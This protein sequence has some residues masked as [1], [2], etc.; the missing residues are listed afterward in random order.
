[1]KPYIMAIDQGTT[2]TRAIL[3]NRQSEIVALYQEA[4]PLMYPHPGYV[5]V[6]ASYIWE[7]TI[8]VMQK[9]VQQSAISADDIHA[10]G[11]TNQRETT[12][13]WDKETG[14]PI[15]N[16]LVWQSRQ[17]ASLCEELKAQGWSETIKQRTGLV[18]DPYFSATK[19]KWILEHVHGA[20]ELAKQGRLLF[21]TVET[22]LI[23]NMTNGQNHIT[24]VSNA[25]RTMMFNIVNR[26]WDKD[27]LEQLEIPYSMLPKVKSSSEVYG[28]LDASILG[29]EIPIAGAAGDQ[30]AALFGQTAF[31]RGDVKNKYG[32]GCFMLMNTGE[33]LVHSKYGLL[34]TIAWE[35]EGKLE[36][37]LEGSVFIA[38]AAVQW[39]RD[40][41]EMINDSHETQALAES[42][43]STAGVYFVPA[44]VGLG[45]PY[46]NADVRGAMFGLTRGSN[47]AHIARAVLESLAYQSRDL[48]TVMEEESGVTLTSMAVD[49]GAIQNEFLMQFQSDILGIAVERPAVS[50]STALG[51]AY[52]AGLATQFWDSKAQIASFRKMDKVFFPHMEEPTREQ[53]YKGWKR[54]VKAAIC[55][56]E[57]ETK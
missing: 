39:L 32:T 57:D 36:Y 22:W 31:S 11:I 56:S 25:S 55:F 52:L 42:V 8:K 5:E 13:V 23:W 15:Y 24:D 29:V 30:Q 9:L 4:L 7:S 33:Q 21:G 6:D 2:S 40:G 44:F 35:V 45:T 49:G 43:D 28:Y 26:E 34:T 3:F 17:T 27:I 10:I 53:L 46:W 51:A 18:I 20:K 54:A 16:G 14:K 41:L 48:L 38:G 1:M 50:E 12:I 47:K 19:V 37:A